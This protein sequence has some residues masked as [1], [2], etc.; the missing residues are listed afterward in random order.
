VDHD[1][2]EPGHESLPWI[3]FWGFTGIAD[4]P[5]CAER[6]EA[7]LKASNDQSGCRDSPT[8]K[9]GLFTVPTP[10]SMTFNC[11]GADFGKAASLTLSCK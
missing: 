5:A 2:P 8:P 9:A 6:T 3:R 7:V 1:G 4:P 11:Y 10:D